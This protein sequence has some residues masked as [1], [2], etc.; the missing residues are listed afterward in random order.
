MS[1]GSTST[2]N[3]RVLIISDDASGKSIFHE[4]QADGAVT[5]RLV[6]W[7][8][9]ALLALEM[10]QPAVVVLDVGGSVSPAK[11]A[12]YELV[13]AELHPQCAML[14]TVA[15]DAQSGVSIESLNRSL[16]QTIA[17][18]LMEDSLA[19]SPHADVSA[20]MLG[21]SQANMQVIQ[22]M[23]RLSS[24]EVPVLIQGE[25]GTGKRLIARML[26]HG[27]MGGSQ[28]S[29]K[30]AGG[31]QADRPKGPLKLVQCESMSESALDSLLFGSRVSQ[32]PGLLET[33]SHGTIV[34]Q[35]LAA[36]S[37]AIQL[38]L[39]DRMR[40]TRFQASMEGGPALIFTTSQDLGRL[41]AS[42]RVRADLFYELSAYLIGLSPLRHRSTDIPI[43]VDHY[44]N[45]V[46]PVL[47]ASGH[48]SLR[49]SASQLERLTQFSW[50]GNLTQLRQVLLRAVLAN[51]TRPLTDH[52][53]LQLMHQR[54]SS[55]G[56]KSYSSP[57]P[58]LPRISP[59]RDRETLLE[60][61]LS[62]PVPSLTIAPANSHS[63][64]TNSHSIGTKSPSANPSR[65]DCESLPS[66]ASL[67][68]ASDPSQWT[69]L[70]D[71]FA[72]EGAS[73]LYARALEQFER[74]LLS[75]VLGRTGGDLNG[76]ARLLGMTRVSLR[77]KIQA[78]AIPLPAPPVSPQKSDV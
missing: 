8:P 26:H 64:G 59:L 71:R 27:S 5:P 22:A 30:Q 61:A 42:R 12:I 58:S 33:C 50:P 38:R 60:E 17:N 44:L 68:R 73:N 34:L 23:R 49:L 47:E 24:L 6:H 29:L 72:S 74:G 62:A 20:W 1:V 18:R 28:G 43:L 52:H 7:S 51:A 65:L 55:N 67:T 54:S 35:E 13:I 57:L 70:V 37:P 78:L 32:E 39:L 75:E 69:E 63:I 15:R 77:N 56:T 48:I 4:L 40:A 16:L 45:S 66:I 36:I 46:A 21:R 2:S 53:L 41:V 25:P 9:R 3:S 11:A 10:W 14:R 19:T 31:K 76:S